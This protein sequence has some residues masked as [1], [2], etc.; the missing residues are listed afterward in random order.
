MKDDHGREISYLRVSVTKRCNLNCVYCGRTECEKKEKELSPDELFT[1]SRA[2]ADCGFR[3]IRLTGGEPLLR[4]DICEIT[5]KLA[6]IPQIRT[7][8]MTTNGVY[9]KRY[10]SELKAAGLDSV[11]ISLDS[12]DGSTYRKLT[13]ADVL[14][15]VLEGID[16]AR[17]VGLS[18]IKI[19]AVLM[20][21][22]NDD[23]AGALIE[24]ARTTPT[25]VRFIEI[26]PFAE[27][28]RYDRCRVTADEILERFPFL[29][30]VESER[31]TA[32]YYS[33]P[34]F[35][36]RVGLISPISR[37]FCGECDRIRLLSDGTVKP[38]LADPA[39]YDLKPFLDD[40]EKL[41]AEIE[42]IVKN[43]PEGHDLTH[44]SPAHGLDLT[45][46]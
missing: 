4:K 7:L 36:G 35:L 12:T 46:G 45:G 28:S 17:R 9:L 10:A 25:D 29:A 11:N 43:K 6:S 18:P 21:G 13:G 24:L 41:K 16:E 23:S 39:V 44:V 31:G 38:C 2:F 1:L 32:E 15:R 19:N 40:A 26:M 14:R 42:R 22:V 37:R 5:E 30:P 33:A 20:K 8:S 34:G 27:A 3:K